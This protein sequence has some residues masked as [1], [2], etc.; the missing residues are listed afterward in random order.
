MGTHLSWSSATM[1]EVMLG[2][3]PS[4]SAGSRERWSPERIIE[5]LRARHAAGLALTTRAV[6]REEPKLYYAACSHFGGWREALSAAGIDP[7]E[8]P[9]RPRVTREAVVA[10][11]RRWAESAP[12]KTASELQK[13]S[14]RLYMRAYRLFGSWRAICE[15]AGLPPSDRTPVG[16]DP[17]ATLP[18]AEL[19]ELWQTLRPRPL[20]LRAAIVRRFGS[21]QGLRDHLGIAVHWTPEKVVTALREFATSGGQVTVDGLRRAGRSGLAAAAM[22]LFPSFEA[23][24]LAAGI[25]PEEPG[26][27]GMAGG[28]GLRSSFRRP[29]RKWTSEAVIAELRQCALSGRP[30]TRTELRRTGRGALASAASRLFGSFERARK[31]A[32]LPEAPDPSTRWAELSPEELYALWRSERPRPRGLR[33]AIRRRFGSV[34]NLRKDLASGLRWNAEKVTEVLR[35]FARSGRAVTASELGKAHQWALLAA[36]YRYHG[37]L[38][39][40]RRAAGLPPGLHRGRG[41]RRDAQS[42]ARS[43]R[44]KLQTAYTR[45]AGQGRSSRLG[46]QIERR[47]GSIQ[48]FVGFLSHERVWTKKAVVQALRELEAKG[49]RV[50][51][52]TVRRA[53]SGLLYA[54]Y[55]L[56][57]SL[58]AARRAAG[59]AEPVDRRLKGL[60]SDLTALTPLELYRLRL[61]HPRSR[62]VK[63]EVRRRYGSLRAFEATEGF[64]SRLTGEQVLT[65]LRECIARGC[66]DGETLWRTEPNVAASAVRLFG[67]VAAAWERAARAQA[68]SSGT[69]NPDEPRRP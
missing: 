49:L 23:A 43:E 47:F 5:R 35:E 15:A 64:T 56:F 52:R 69:G 39:A 25:G 26:P 42:L 10:E 14:P 45:W 46:R 4:H 28:D 18:P 41:V 59:V 6:L 30:V 8:A 27:N 58:A 57:G 61:E 32:G 12:V 60:P 54:V 62:R 21:I 7:A 29:R 2:P 31:A 55:H 16:E 38:E 65:A 67:S 9:R 40:A 19:Y 17:Y 50:D 44:A 68:D 48:R 1:G 20:T 11:L 13:A 37:S 22:R 33:L 24:R 3:M 66:K 51:A 34:A 63:A 53:D 36:V